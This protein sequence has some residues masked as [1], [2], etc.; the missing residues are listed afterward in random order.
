MRIYAREFYLRGV[1]VFFVTG[2][3]NIYLS[4]VRTM[5]MMCYR[6]LICH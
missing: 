1:G 6:R 3:K 2:Q 4:F 5:I